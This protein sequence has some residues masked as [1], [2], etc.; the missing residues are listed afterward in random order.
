MEEIRYE[1][2]FYNFK[3]PVT[4]I[5]NPEI[6][7]LQYVFKVA[8]YFQRKLN[9]PAEIIADQVQDYSLRPSLE[10]YCP[11][12]DQIKQ[13]LAT[14]GYKD[15]MADCG[16]DADSIYNCLEKQIWYCRMS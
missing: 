13:V 14:D 3:P 7:T 2:T 1:R 8:P 5:D 9:L 15:L 11:D 4:V 6:D 16:T 10:K 12:L